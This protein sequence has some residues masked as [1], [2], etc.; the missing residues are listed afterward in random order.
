MALTDRARTL[1]ALVSCLALIASP[2][3]VRA[4][5]PSVLADLPLIEA[6]APTQ[7]RTFAIFLS[8]DGGWASIDKNVSAALQ[9]RGIGV[10]GINSLKYF[11]RTRTAEGTAEDFSRIIREYARA[12][13]AESVVFIGYSRGAGVVPFVA[14]RL[15]LD[16]RDRLRLIVLL[17]AEHTAGFRFRVS[18]LWGGARKGEPP[19]MPEVRKLAAVAL[20]CFYGVEETDTLCPELTASRHVAVKLGGGHHFDGNYAAIGSRIADELR[21]P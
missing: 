17:G 14:N 13:R 2:F 4:Q 5:R 20:V 10:V 19:V 6:A 7:G 11:W 18:D 1:R 12:W 9:R 8:G 21:K 3:A 16:V 15:D